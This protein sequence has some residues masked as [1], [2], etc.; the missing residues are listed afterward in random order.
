MQIAMKHPPERQAVMNTIGSSIIDACCTHLDQNE[1]LGLLI[2]LIV[3]FTLQQQ[4]ASYHVQAGTIE[5]VCNEI[6]RLHSEATNN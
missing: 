4:N 1:T 5:S 6:C 2:G 3:S